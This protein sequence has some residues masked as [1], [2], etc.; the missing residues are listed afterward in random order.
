MSQI[1]NNQLKALVERIESLEAEKAAL[2]Q[3]VKDVLAEAKGQGF[4]P[5]ILKKLIAL[6]KQDADKRD[7]ERIMID[8]YLNSLGQLAETP[9]GRAAVERQFS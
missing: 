6:R 7:E 4:D 5:K 1:N 3:D 8:L 9:L 2:A